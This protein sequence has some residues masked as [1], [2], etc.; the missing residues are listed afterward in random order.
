MAKLFGGRLLI[1]FEQ[2]ST[3]RVRLMYSTDADI[4]RP[5]DMRTAGPSIVGQGIA[6]DNAGQVAIIYSSGT[7]RL[8][9]AG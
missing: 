3:V 4:W 7:I 5:W 2:E 8:F 6:T 1:G 9:G